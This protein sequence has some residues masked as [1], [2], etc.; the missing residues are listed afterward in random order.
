LSHLCL[1]LFL[2]SHSL[3]EVVHHLRST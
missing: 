3:A 2:V 1:S